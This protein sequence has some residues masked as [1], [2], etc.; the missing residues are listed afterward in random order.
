[1]MGYRHKDKKE[2]DLQI[3]IDCIENGVARRDIAAREGL[4]LARICRILQEQEHGYKV[5]QYKRSRKPRRGFL[6]QL[7][8]DYVAIRLKV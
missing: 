1:M 3:Y 5:R 7:G 4:T 6:S 2:R 8:M